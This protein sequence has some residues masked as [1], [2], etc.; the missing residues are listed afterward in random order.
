MKPSTTKTMAWTTMTAQKLA[1]K[2]GSQ[3]S[4]VKRARLGPMMPASTPPAVT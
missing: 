3:R 4:G 2:V 1:W